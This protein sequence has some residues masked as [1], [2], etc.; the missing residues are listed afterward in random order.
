MQQFF[1]ASLVLFWVGQNVMAVFVYVGDAQAK[2]LPLITGV[3]ILTIG[4]I[5]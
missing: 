3:Q 1:S 4:P 5:F 2:A